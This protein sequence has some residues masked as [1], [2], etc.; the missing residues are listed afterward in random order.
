MILGILR[1]IIRIQKYEINLMKDS[2][3]NTNTNTELNDEMS[4]E[5]IKM[6]KSY[7]HTQWDYLQLMV[8]FR[9]EK[10]HL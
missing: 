1:D 8:Q 3:I 2:K 7:L 6:D 9:L 5:N 4:N 10:R